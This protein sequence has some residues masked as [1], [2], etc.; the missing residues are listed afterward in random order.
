[1]GNGMR[2]FSK[3]KNPERALMALGLLR[4]DEEINDLFCYGVEGVHY[5]NNGDDTV[6]LPDEQRLWLR[7]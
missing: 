3:F 1:M 7:R 6:T 5:Q 4:N 2:I